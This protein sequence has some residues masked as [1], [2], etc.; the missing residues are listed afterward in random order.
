M[1]L[2]STEHLHGFSSRRP[3]DCR[4]LDFMSCRVWTVFEGNAGRV[5]TNTA[6]PEILVALLFAFPIGVVGSRR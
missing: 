6:G 1:D 4:C 2:S 3:P 5:G